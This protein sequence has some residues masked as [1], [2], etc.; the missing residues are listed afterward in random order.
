MILLFEE[1]VG[2]E[3][4]SL[5]LILEEILHSLNKH[6]RILVFTLF[7]ED[8]DVEHD[9]LLVD[10]KRLLFHQLQHEQVGNVKN[11]RFEFEVE[12]DEVH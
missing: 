2:F 12:T 4:L 1:Q 6:D 11:L 5:S 3:A 10:F 9:E 8:L 7:L